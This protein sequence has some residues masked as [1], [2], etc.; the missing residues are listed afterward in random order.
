MID[1]VELQNIIGYIR[2]LEERKSKQVQEKEEGQSVSV[3]LSHRLQ[4]GQ[5]VNY[6]YLS[7]KVESIRSQLQK[8]AYEVSPEKI[9][10]GLEKFLSSK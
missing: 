8:N 9:L 4:G 7:K 2:E 6:E 10:Q 1:R 5:E 3:E